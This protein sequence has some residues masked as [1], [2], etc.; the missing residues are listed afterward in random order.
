MLRVRVVLESR[1]SEVTIEEVL[2][3]GK[4]ANSDPLSTGRFLQQTINRMLNFR[5]AGSEVKITA[6]VVEARDAYR[7]D[8]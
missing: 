7:K 3:E 8:D 1:N 6:T 2:L 5:E 4:Q